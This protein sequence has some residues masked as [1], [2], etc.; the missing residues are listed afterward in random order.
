MGAYLGYILTAFVAT[1][2]HEPEVRVDSQ[3]DIAC[4]TTSTVI[5]DDSD[6]E[7]PWHLKKRQ[8]NDH[9]VVR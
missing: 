9:D 3:S 4:C 7:M 6:E 1:P 5:Y 8:V 2:A